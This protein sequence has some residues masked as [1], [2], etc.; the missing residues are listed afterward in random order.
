MLLDREKIITFK[1]HTNGLDIRKFAKQFKSSTELVECTSH[2]KAI[3]ADILAMPKFWVL[4]FLLA[5]IKKLDGGLESLK[6]MP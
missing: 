1:G 3:G 6:S 2:C 5:G 4:V